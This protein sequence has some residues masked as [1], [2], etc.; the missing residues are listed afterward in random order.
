MAAPGLL[1]AP[2]RWVRSLYD[3]TMHWADT[4]W[5]LSALFVIAFAESS[6]FPIPPDV[7]LIA[8]VA[9]NPMRWLPAALLCSAGSVGG[10]LLGYLIGQAFM[11]TV[12]QPIVDF[13]GAQAAWDQV[14]ALY[15]GTWGVW[16]L[17]AAAFTPIP[18]KVATIAAG[19]T[20]MPI[21]PFIIVSAI[22]RAGRFFLVAGLLRIFGPPIRTF[23]E[24][25]FDA[26]A[27]AFLAL[28]I[29][30]FVILRFL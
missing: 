25:H 22:G 10:A 9:A 29:G 19:A 28:L 24:K 14:V 15:R 16:F 2:R 13:Y 30:G 4:K 7:L 17:A 20:G 23:L 21:V 27:L 3:W 26:M 11:A 8:I 5:A 1:A 12:G 18:Y 6:F